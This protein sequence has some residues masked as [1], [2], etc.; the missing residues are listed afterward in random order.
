MLQN[1]SATILLSVKFAAAAS[2]FF[3][4]HSLSLSRSI[5]LCANLFIYLSYL[6]PAA[7]PTVNTSKCVYAKALNKKKQIKQARRK[8]NDVC[9]CIIMCV[10]F[11]SVF[12]STLLVKCLYVS[13]V[14]CAINIYLYSLLLF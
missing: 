11:F 12:L 4:V 6:C 3:F 2:F 8:Q 10:C 7:I 1:V 14:H 9:C 5:I 13:Y